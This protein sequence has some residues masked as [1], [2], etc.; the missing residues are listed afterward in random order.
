[1]FTVVPLK[2]RQS[3]APEL[4]VAALFVNRHNA[5]VFVTVVFA[6]QNQEMTS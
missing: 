4:R 6:Q 2:A 1:M 3:S 5:A